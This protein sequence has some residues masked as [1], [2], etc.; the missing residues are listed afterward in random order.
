MADPTKV[1][2]QAANLGDNV[3]SRRYVAGSLPDTAGRLRAQSS[4]AVHNMS[5]AASSTLGSQACSAPVRKVA[6]NV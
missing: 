5:L 6:G 1:Y 2:R 4:T 3:L